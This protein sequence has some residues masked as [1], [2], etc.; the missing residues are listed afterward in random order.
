MLTKKREMS[1]TPVSY[2]DALVL[3][4]SGGMGKVGG[5]LTYTNSSPSGQ[6]Q[7]FVIC[8]DC[9]LNSTLAQGTPLTRAVFNP[10]PCKTSQ[11]TQPPFNST[12]P[13]AGQEGV[14][15]NINDIFYLGEICTL[16]NPPP[17]WPSSLAFVS[18]TGTYSDL[19]ATDIQNYPENGQIQALNVQGYG[20]NNTFLYGETTFQLALE[21]NSSTNINGILYAYTPR[22]IQGYPSIVPSYGGTSELV[23][24]TFTFFQA[25]APVGC[26]GVGSQKGQN[27]RPPVA[28]LPF[29]NTRVSNSDPPASLNADPPITTTT[30]NG[31]LGDPVSITTIAFIG[32][33]VL[34]LIGSI[35]PIPFLC[36]KKSNKKL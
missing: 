20:P 1:G 25:A 35:I 11:V 17:N 29:K 16:S 22:T 5:Y 21:R 14:N 15:M 28:L 32:L 30:T 7:Y 26:S 27:Y 4:C 19:H 9:P 13:F 36:R 8:Y 33:L 31:K 2:G 6:G 3:Y 12:D 18:S 34:I 24:L 10:V 23:L